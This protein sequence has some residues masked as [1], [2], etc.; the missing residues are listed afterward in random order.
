[1]LPA[2]RTAPWWVTFN[3]RRAPYRQ[4]KMGQRDGRTDGR[5]TVKLRFKWQQTWYSQTENK[6]YQ[7]YPTIPSYS[8]LPSC[9]LKGQIL[10]NRL[11]IGHTYL[12]IHLTSV[13]KVIWQKAASPSCHPS[14]WRM[15]PSAACTGQAHSPT[16]ADE[17]CKG[18]AHIA[19]Q[20]LPF[21]LGI[22]TRI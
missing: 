1:M 8:I 13:Q 21:P 17:Q 20:K 12:S 22:W 14:R 7:I 2:S 16:T 3:M 6:L 10:H 9:Q 4:K 15:H 11:C 18:L 5:H 19:P